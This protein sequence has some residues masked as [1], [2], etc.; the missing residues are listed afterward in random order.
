MRLFIARIIL[1]LV[2]ILLTRFIYGQGFESLNGFEMFL[3]LLPGY[4][5]AEL[6]VSRLKEQ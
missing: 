4:F 5:L 1:L 2:A 3:V 6:I